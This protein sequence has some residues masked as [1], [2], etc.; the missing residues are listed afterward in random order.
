MGAFGAGVVVVG[1]LASAPGIADQAGSAPALAALLAAPA[2]GGLVV[3]GLR[4]RHARLFAGGAPAGLAVAAV[5]LALA[6]VA[7]RPLALLCALAVAGAGAGVALGRRPNL[8]AVPAGG[9][10]GVLAS[11]ATNTT[12][13]SLIALCALVY[14][15]A[16]A[17]AVAPTGHDRVVRRVPAAPGA[18]ALMP[19]V[20]AGL[21]GATML[22]MTGARGASAG[23]TRVLLAIALL[24]A[25]AAPWGLEALGARGPDVAVRRAGA[26]GAAILLAMAAASN[27]GTPTL[28][29]PLMVLALVLAA[30]IGPARAPS[31]RLLAAIMLGAAAGTIAAQAVG[32]TL[33]LSLLAGT[34]LVSWA[35]SGSTV[36]APSRAARRGA[37]GVRAA[38]A[39]GAAAEEDAPDA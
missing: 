26:L 16:V 9:G 5:A 39:E 10:A 1:V 2:A 23:E 37:R 22:L 25:A 32:T 4:A 34:A 15:T 20:W 18:L 30:G 31:G 3:A 27:V 13:I 38:L 24:C 33:G 19:I 28:T 8:A 7:T 14:A 36:E 35:L 12:E 11:A 17:T 6:A 21:A 29:G